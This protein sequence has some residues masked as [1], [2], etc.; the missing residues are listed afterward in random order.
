MK[1]GYYNKYLSLLEEISVWF[2]KLKA[3]KKVFDFS[4]K[5]I[6]QLQDIHLLLNRAGHLNLKIFV[7]GFLS[8]LL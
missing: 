7:A 4:L 6:C 2:T 1:L 8:Y 3:G 5:N